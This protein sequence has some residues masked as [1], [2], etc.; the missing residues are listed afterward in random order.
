MHYTT[1]YAL[2]TDNETKIVALNC[3]EE[4]CY[5]MGCFLRLD[6]PG[7]LTFLLRFLFQNYISEY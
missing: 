4:N 3:F 5:L 2:A 7:Q 6:R 1:W